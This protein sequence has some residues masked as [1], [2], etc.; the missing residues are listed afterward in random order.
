M[1]QN[2]VIDFNKTIATIYRREQ[3]VPLS[4]RDSFPLHGKTNSLD[5]LQSSAKKV[6]TKKTFSLQTAT[7]AAKMKEMKDISFFFFWLAKL[8]QDRI[9]H[10]SQGATLLLQI[11]AD[12]FCRSS[13]V[14]Q[15]LGSLSASTSQIHKWMTD[16]PWKFYILTSPEY[17]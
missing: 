15:T 12:V 11:I 13:L 7:E 8:T 4:T 2:K 9:G 16:L 17:G 14:W 10:T 1:T 5:T 3:A 6:I